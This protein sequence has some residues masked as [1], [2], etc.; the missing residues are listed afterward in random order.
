LEFPFSNFDFPFSIFEQEGVGFMK[1]EEVRARLEEIGIMPIVRVSSAEEAR[2]AAE[3]VASGGIPIVEVAMTVP[4][5]SEVIS[6]LVRSA[7]EM[8]VGA[9]SVLDTEM[10]QLC[11]DAGAK[12]LTSEGFDLEVVEFAVKEGVV[13]LPGA[14]TPTEVITAWKA[15]ADFVK[16]FPCAQLGGDSYIR[17]LK[18]ALPQVPL[19]AAGGVNQ[20][21]AGNFVLA[22]AAALGVGRELIPKE[23]I[24][25]RRPEWIREL[26]RRFLG[27]VKNARSQKAAWKGSAAARK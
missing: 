2:F 26:A 9:G 11:V 27:L 17:A 19:I 3:A 18:V 7:P 1:R 21:T 25:Q 4:G 13:V 15:A 8:I 12:F 20:L 14:L 5:A 24:Q 23:A 22:G 10:A 6:Q 16:V